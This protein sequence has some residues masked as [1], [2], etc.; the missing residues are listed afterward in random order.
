M[1]NIAFLVIGLV[2][3]YYVY[4]MTKKKDTKPETSFKEDVETVSNINYPGEMSIQ[5][6]LVET[7]KKIADEFGI[8]TARK[9]EQMARLETNHFKSGGFQ[10]TMGMGMEVPKSKLNSGYPFGWPSMKNYWDSIN[11]VPEIVNMN[12]NHPTLGKGMGPVKHF[13]KFPNVMVGLTSLAHFV[14][15]RK[16]EEWR[17]LDPVLQAT[18]RNSVNKITPKITNAIANV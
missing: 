12:E 10:R 18:Y 11:F 4:R 7:F 1:K 9:V 15:N 3:A 8:D 17:A 5:K 2:I 6:Q 13:I 16:W 14:K